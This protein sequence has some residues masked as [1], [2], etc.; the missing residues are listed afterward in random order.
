MGIL[1]LTQLI[2]SLC[3]EA[4][5]HS[6]LYALEGK[7]VAIDLM[8]FGYKFWAVSY[9]EEIGRIDV[10]TQSPD[11]DRAFQHFVEL[12]KIQIDRFFHYQILPIFVIDSSPSSEK[13]QH[14]IGKRR[15]QREQ[16][17][18]I[19]DRLRS[20]IQEK[21]VLSSE[22]EIE[23]LRKKLL[24]NGHFNRPLQ[25]RLLEFLRKLGLPTLQAGGMTGEADKV[26]AYLHRK[27]YVQGL[28]STDRDF[29]TFGAPSLIVNY[30]IRKYDPKTKIDQYYFEVIFLDLILEKLEITYPQF[31]DLCIL[32][33]CD[34][35]EKLWRSSIFTIFDLI[36]QYGKIE[37][38]PEKYDVSKTNYQI[39]R[40]YFTSN[41]TLSQL[42]PE[43][44]RFEI[45]FSV[46]SRL[47]ETLQE[48]HLSEW[49]EQLQIYYRNL[50]EYKTVLRGGK[51]VRI[52]VRE[53]CCSLDDIVSN[54]QEFLEPHLKS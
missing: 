23:D 9:R 52:R 48:Y 50:S 30:G 22:K 6:P 27:G 31:V 36:K 26:C 21:G 42:L 32:A 40:K 47:K 51:K 7:K 25:L 34:Y 16:R 43:N 28:I 20:Q 45:D 5:V 37:N 41:E 44:P 11:L 19:I 12:I 39:A 29:L 46:F 1:K 18:S 17:E 38:L 10:A 33:G 2:K 49:F 13:Y 15:S 3:P 54:S 24:Y 35:G 53:E 8:N 14:V 4:I